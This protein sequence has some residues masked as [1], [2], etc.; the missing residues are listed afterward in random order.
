MFISLRWAAS[1][2]VS[3]TTC[4]DE[5]WFQHI[6]AQN[7][8]EMIFT[9]TF[10]FGPPTKLFEQV[11]P[12]FPPFPMEMLLWKLDKISFTNYEACVS[13]DQQV[14]S[15]I[16][17]KNERDATVFVV[18]WRWKHQ[19]YSMSLNSQGCEISDW[20]TDKYQNFANWYIIKGNIVTNFPDNEKNCIPVGV[21]QNLIYW[22]YDITLSREKVFDIKEK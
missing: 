4:A 13:A 17:S 5:L 15:C 16:W 18:Q 22:V 3:I 9:G 21:K 19:L 14:H 10:S 20:W 2:V 7:S 11:N 1:N 8:R 12:Y 6:C